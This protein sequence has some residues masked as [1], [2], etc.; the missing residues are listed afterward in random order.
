[1]ATPENRTNPHPG[2]LV[3]TRADVRRLLTMRECIDAVEDAFRRHAAAPT[4]PPGVIG[5]HVDGG[6]FHVKTAALHASR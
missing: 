6:G 1:M 2:T 3:L 5:T 4:G